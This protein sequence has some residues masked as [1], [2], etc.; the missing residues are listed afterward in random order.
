[1]WK[2][3]LNTL[4]LVTERIGLEVGREEYY[5]FLLYIAFI[6]MRRYYFII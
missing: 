3:V 2:D 1:M 4:A 6:S 5:V